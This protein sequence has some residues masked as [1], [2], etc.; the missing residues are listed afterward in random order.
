MH[1]PAYALIALLSAS[2]AGLAQ[3]SLQALFPLPA[4]SGPLPLLSAVVLGGLL[5][6]GLALW[7]GA[8]AVRRPSAL[9]WVLLVN[10]LLLLVLMLITPDAPPVN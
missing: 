6:L 5:G 8:R 7:R 1:M 10:A 9:E 3:A 2:Y 4:L